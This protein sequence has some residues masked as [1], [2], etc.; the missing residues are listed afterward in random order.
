[1]SISFGVLQLCGVWLKLKC[2]KLGSALSVEFDE[3]RVKWFLVFEYG[4]IQMREIE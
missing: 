2:L 1:M 3:Q 4:C